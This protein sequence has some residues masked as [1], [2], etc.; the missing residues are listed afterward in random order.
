M[1]VLKYVTTM[2]S[3]VISCMALTVWQYESADWNF[4]D[5]FFM[6]I[7]FSAMVVGMQ[8]FKIDN[9]IFSYF[10][11]VFALWFP[12][13]AIYHWLTINEWTKWTVYFSILFIISS[14]LFFAV[15]LADCM[16]K[17]NLSVSYYIFLPMAV[18]IILAYI[19]SYYNGNTFATM[20][21]FVYVGINISQAID[22]WQR[23]EQEDKYYE[24]DDIHINPTYRTLFFKSLCLILLAAIIYS[25]LSFLSN[26]Y[27]LT[28]LTRPCAFYYV[29]ETFMP[30]PGLAWLLFCCF[31]SDKVS[32][33]AKNTLLFIQSS[34]V[35]ARVFFDLRLKCLDSFFTGTDNLI[36][37]LSLIFF[38]AVYC[39]YAFNTAKTIAI[40]SGIAYISLTCYGFIAESYP[41]DEMSVA[42]LVSVF[43]FVCTIISN[44]IAD[45][46]FENEMN[47]ILEHLK[48]AGQSVSYDELDRIDES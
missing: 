25:A 1:N 8:L 31:G 13:S 40:L 10:K 36:G 5:D 39:Y 19:N 7:I 30:L 20:C 21:I 33:K 26:I 37:V 42:M 2:F 17:R 18:N 3:F 29:A 41:F 27:L 48:A 6:L 34:L 4:K 15:Q 24:C 14:V 12:V 28:K 16:E 9:K 43:A 38:M 47:V 45:R 22:N 44:C 32:V 35:A 23:Q 11:A 46:K